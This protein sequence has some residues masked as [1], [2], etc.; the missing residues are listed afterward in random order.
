M[1]YKLVN[2]PG[3]WEAIPNTEGKY[4]TQRYDILETKTNQIVATKP[5]FND[6]AKRLCGHLNG[7]GGFNGHTPEFFLSSIPPIKW[8][9][10]EISE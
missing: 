5:G 2:K 4:V 10:S 1:N 3:E 6:E 8:S 9:A 7:G